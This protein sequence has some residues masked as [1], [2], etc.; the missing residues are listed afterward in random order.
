MAKKKKKKEIDYTDNFQSNGNAYKRMFKKAPGKVKIFEFQI[1]KKKTIKIKMKFDKK[2]EN[3]RVL[4]PFP[5][6]KG[7]KIILCTD[8]VS[9]YGVLWDF[10]RQ[11]VASKEITNK[12]RRDV[13]KFLQSYFKLESKSIQSMYQLDFVKKKKVKNAKL[14]KRK[15]SKKSRTSKKSNRK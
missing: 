9:M 13:E 11:A 7:G 2:K 5:K 15:I 14:S 3:V 10:V 8:C 1:S 6:S 12:K 4:T